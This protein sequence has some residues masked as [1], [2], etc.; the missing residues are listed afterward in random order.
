MHVCKK[1]QKS[2]T[3]VFTKNELKIKQRTYKAASM[4]S[5]AKDAS[6]QTKDRASTKVASSSSV[7][8][9]ASVAGP[10]TGPTASNGA[11]CCQQHQQQQR[12]QDRLHVHHWAGG[13]RQV[14]G[15]VTYLNHS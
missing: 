13:K 9:S 5:S 15:G 11:D 10:E 1:V 2:A 8:S 3:A 12:S 7:V 4:A 6:H 14:R